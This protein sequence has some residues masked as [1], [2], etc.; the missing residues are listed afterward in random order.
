MTREAVMQEKRINAIVHGRVQGV[1]FRDHTLKEARRLGLVGWVRNC[2]D[3]TVE[4]VAQGEPQQVDALLSWL[5]Q[6]SPLSE[7]KQVDWRE[8]PAG[9]DLSL[10]TVLYT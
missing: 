9:H 1:W 4:V 8:E 3:G 5:H 10:F 2:I 7:V 6:G